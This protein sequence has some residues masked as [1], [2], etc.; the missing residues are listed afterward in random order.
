MKLAK[1]ATKRNVLTTTG[2]VIAS[3]RDSEQTDIKKRKRT[4]MARITFTD[5]GDTQLI[6]VEAVDL[7]YVRYM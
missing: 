7:K 4:I 3:V 2:P 5:H 6:E 1:T